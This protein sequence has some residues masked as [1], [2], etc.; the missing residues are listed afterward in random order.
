MRSTISS[1]EAATEDSPG[2]RWMQERAAA[3]AHP[4]QLL[5]DSGAFVLP[6]PDKVAKG[7]ED[8]LFIST[9]QRAIGIADG[10]GGW[11]DVGV[12]P[13]LYAR[14]LMKN[15]SETVDL[16]LRQSPTL[17]AQSVLED[18]VRKTQIIGSSTACVLVVN[19]S[20]LV[21]SNPGEQRSSTVLFE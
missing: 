5:L 14:L 4:P 3:A 13:A 21:A 7:G 10:V 18:A 17:S 19:G 2:Y 1:S 8:W 9:S 15:A 6:H 16:Q 20:N 11:A 12:D